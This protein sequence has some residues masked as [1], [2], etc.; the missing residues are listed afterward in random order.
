MNEP[1]ALLITDD[2]LPHLGGSRIYYHQVASMLA[3]GLSVL[4]RKRAGDGDFDSKTTYRIR[5]V[6]LATGVSHW[7]SPAEIVD[8]LTL[9]R[10]ALTWFPETKIYVAGELNPSCMA[11]FIAAKR[12]GGA[13][14]VV[15]HDEQRAGAGKVE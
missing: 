5:R 3:P 9:A 4:T 6:P 10:K 11:A 14:G 8:C 15:L 12:R 1:Q 13:Y 7:R 2:Y